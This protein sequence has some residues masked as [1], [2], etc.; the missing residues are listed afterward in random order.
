MGCSTKHIYISPRGV[1]QLVVRLGVDFFT[2]N[3]DGCV[4]G[5]DVNV[6]VGHFFDKSGKRELA[7]ISDRRGGKGEG[8]ITW[9]ESFRQS[10]AVASRHDRTGK[11]RKHV[12]HCV[13]SDEKTE[14]IWVSEPRAEKM[15]ASSQPI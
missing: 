13:E 3:A 1:Y 7:R 10:R 11:R 14:T 12:E 2:P 5:V 6:R 9:F 4:V 8:G 15:P